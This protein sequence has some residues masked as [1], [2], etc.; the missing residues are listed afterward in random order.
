[1]ADIYCRQKTK[2]TRDD[3]KAVFIENRAKRHIHTPP[4]N[5]DEDGTFCATG[6]VDADNEKDKT[7]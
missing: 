3:L 6:I 2:E 4:G 7:A 1:M 5:F